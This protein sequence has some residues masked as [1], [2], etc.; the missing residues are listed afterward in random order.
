MKDAA[1]TAM[2]VASSSRTAGV[3]CGLTATR[4]C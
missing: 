1:D 2:A 3:Q 4:I